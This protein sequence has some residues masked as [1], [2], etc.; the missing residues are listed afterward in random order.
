MVGIKSGIT[1]GCLAT[2]CAWINGSSLA[3]AIIGLYNHRN[4]SLDILHLVA[5][6]KYFLPYKRLIYSA[7]QF[8]GEVGEKFAEGDLYHGMYPIANC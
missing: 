1:S 6:G 4:L 2:T 7:L 5:F 8:G 3:T